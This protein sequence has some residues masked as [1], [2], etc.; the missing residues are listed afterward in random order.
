M[1]ALAKE[2][3]KL[4]E[5]W[6][7]ALVDAKTMEITDVTEV[8]DELVSQSE[9]RK[10]KRNLI[11]SCVGVAAGLGI[12]LT[13]LGWLG[14]AVALASGVYGVTGIPK[15]TKLSTPENRLKAAGEGVFFA[16]RAINLL[17]DRKCVVKVEAGKEERQTVFLDGGTGHDKLL[18]AKCMR[19]LFSAVNDQRYLL[20]KAGSRKDEDSFYCVPE[21]FGKRKEDAEMFYGYLKPYIGQYE[22]IYTRNERGKALLLEGRMKDVADAKERSL[23]HKMMRTNK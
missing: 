9:Y 7:T 21:C 13:P 19:E 14:G 2:R 17:E 3:G 4:K 1:L 6:Q 11:L 20:V 23:N 12:S 10:S 18:F 15:T 16:L 22:V 5:R 8:P